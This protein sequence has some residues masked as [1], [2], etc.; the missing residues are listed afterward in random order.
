MSRSWRGSQS[1]FPLLTPNIP[2][3]FQG[4]AICDG[5]GFPF[6]PERLSFW[7]RGFPVGGPSDFGLRRVYFAEPESSTGPKK[8]CF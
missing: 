2:L 4:F 5:Q 1:G 6:S 3:A 8:P 7:E